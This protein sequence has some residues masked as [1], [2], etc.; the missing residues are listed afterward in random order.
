MLVEVEISV[1]TRLSRA[2]ENDFQWLRRR[3]RRLVG[4]TNYS[5]FTDSFKIHP[6]SAFPA[7]SHDNQHALMRRERKPKL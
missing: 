2:D 6:A 1:S 7:Q 4:T 5:H 3:D